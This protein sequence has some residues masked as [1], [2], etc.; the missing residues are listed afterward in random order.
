MLRHM[1]KSEMA[2]SGKQFSTGLYVGGMTDESEVLV[3]RSRSSR[4]VQY[5]CG[6]L[7]IPE[8]DTCFW[9]RRRVTSSSPLQ[10]TEDSRRK[11]E[12]V[13]VDF[14]IQIGL[15]IGLSKKRLKQYQELGYVK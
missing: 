13:V 7:D 15:C 10:D 12:P 1:A 11:K 5:G 8:L 4:N 9:R 2:K 14:V 6:G 3:Q